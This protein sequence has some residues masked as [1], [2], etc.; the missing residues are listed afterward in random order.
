MAKAMVLQKNLKS[1]SMPRWQ[2]IER[3]IN[4]ECGA[5]EEVARVDQKLFGKS[6]WI[7]ETQFEAIYH[8]EQIEK[9]V[10]PNA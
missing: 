5:F 2:G 10:R 6:H 1:T 9:L 7:P 3:R 8:A 4:Q